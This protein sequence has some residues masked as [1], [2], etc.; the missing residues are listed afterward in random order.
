MKVYLD[1]K[2]RII[3][4]GRADVPED[5]GDEFDVSLFGPTSRFEEDFVVANVT[6]LSAAGAIVEER[7]IVLS[8]EQIPE[9]LPGWQP[10][11]S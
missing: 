6:R 4:V 11:A 5:C 3:L 9:V 1:L 7:A 10:L 2:G 8:P